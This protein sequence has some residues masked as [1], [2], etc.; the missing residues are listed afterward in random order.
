MSQSKLYFDEQRKKDVRCL[1][2]PENQKR[3]AGKFPC[4]RKVKGCDRKMNPNR[5]KYRRKKGLRWEIRKPGARFAC[6][7]ENWLT[8]FDW[9]D[10]Y[11]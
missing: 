6:T 2:S 5:A 11:F 10:S 9:L 8:N 7:L 4:L 3:G 1:R